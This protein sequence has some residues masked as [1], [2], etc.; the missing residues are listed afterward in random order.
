[1]AFQIIIMAFQNNLGNMYIK[2]YI[3]KIDL[4]F[5]ILNIIIISLNLNFLIKNFKR[6]I[7]K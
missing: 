4:I 7:L 2:K 6:K 3:I 1:M 5:I